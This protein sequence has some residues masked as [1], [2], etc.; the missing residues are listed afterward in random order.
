MLAALLATPAVAAG[1]ASADGSQAA[2][3][4][5]VGD[6]HLVFHDTATRNGLMGA[7]NQSGIRWARVVFAWSDIEPLD[8]VWLFGAADRAVA[9]AR[10][11]GVKVLVILGFAPRW[12]NGGNLPNWPPPP[13]HYPDWREYV[14]LACG[15]YAADVAAWEIWNEQN[16]RAFWQ[17]EPDASEYVALAGEAA[18]RIRA[19]DPGAT[20][21]M[22]GVAGL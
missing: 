1:N 7:M 12:A 14:S 20:V 2:E 4:F 5:G 3:R 16:I 9:A 22:G 18:P 21:V 11:H 8:G 19:A 17:P 13:D 6:S 10:E 15:R